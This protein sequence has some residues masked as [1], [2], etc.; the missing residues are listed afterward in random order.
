MKLS[1]VSQDIIDP[2]TRD[3]VSKLTASVKGGWSKQHKADGS[4]GT[5]T[6]D[7]VTVGSA[8]VTGAPLNL[9]GDQCWLSGAWLLNASSR[10]QNGEA[11]LIPAQLTA[12]QNNYNPPGLLRATI[13][14]LNSDASRNI[15]GIIPTQGANRWRVLML[16]NSGSQNIVLKQNDTGNS[17]AAN[18]I[19]LPNGADVTLNQS[20][21]IIL[22]YSPI[23]Q[24]WLTLATGV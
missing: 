23:N 21:G 15:T 2:S 8:G 16:T 12:N 11:V 22:L 6:A 19:T 4:H 20:E 5:L 14:V 3:A 24:R 10:G 7:G 13:L 18:C 1:G 9:T 17:A